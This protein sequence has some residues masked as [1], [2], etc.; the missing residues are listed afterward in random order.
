VALLTE[1]VC[2]VWHALFEQHGD[3]ALVNEHI[4]YTE[5]ID[6]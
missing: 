6:V 3:E 2:V 4:K 1:L 5:L